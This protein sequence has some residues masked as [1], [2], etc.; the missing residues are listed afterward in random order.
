M[1]LFL[2][3]SSCLL[4]E[5]PDKLDPLALPENVVQSVRLVRWVLKVLLYVSYLRK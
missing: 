2:I 4:R 3:I 1:E 5:H